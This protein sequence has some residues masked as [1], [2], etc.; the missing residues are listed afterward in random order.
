MDRSVARLAMELGGRHVG[1]HGVVEQQ[2]G[3]LRHGRVE[4][5]RVVVQVLELVVQELGQVVHLL[6]LHQ[7]CRARRRRSSCA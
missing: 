2:L 1:E 5:R 6:V 3:G 7:A 4:G